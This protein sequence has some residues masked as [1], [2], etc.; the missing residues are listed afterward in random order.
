MSE[1]QAGQV[2]GNHWLGQPQDILQVTDAER[3]DV[4]QIDDPQTS[5]FRDSLQEVS[6]GLRVSLIV[7]IYAYADRL[8]IASGLLVA[9]TVVTAARDLA[10]PA[11]SFLCSKG[12]PE[13]FPDG[14]KAI[15]APCNVQTASKKALDSFFVSSNM[16][17]GAG[18]IVDPVRR[19]VRRHG[20]RATASYHAALDQGRTAWLGGRGHSVGTGHSQFHTFAPPRQAEK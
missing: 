19:H 11:G 1:A 5:R 8:I 16:E 13:F 4:Q 10:L 15:V 20:N 17:I 14:K 18:A 9:V 2:P 3:L 12:A 7:C 6:Q